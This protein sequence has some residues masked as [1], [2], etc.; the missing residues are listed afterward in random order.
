MSSHEPVARERDL[1]AGSAV[2]LTA[3]LVETVS[4]ADGRRRTRRSVL[5]CA[6][7]G[8]FLVVAITAPALS[9]DGRLADLFAANSTHLSSSDFSGES[10]ATVARL[11]RSLVDRDESGSEWDVLLLRQ[12][13]R[14]AYYRV[15]WR[16]GAQCVSWGRIPERG[17]R[18]LG[19]FICFSPEDVRAFRASGD[20]IT[21]GWVGEQRPSGGRPDLTGVAGLASDGVVRVVARGADGNSIA[22]ATVNNGAFALGA[23]DRADVAMD[24]IRSLV[25]YGSDGRELGHLARP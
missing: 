23:L 11:A 13:A 25:A 21:A 17:P 10:R 24:E 9:L 18:E 1:P 8:T 19:P 15:T 6:V 4:S 5:A 14:R 2:A 16:N 22:S 3:T 7:A 12:D 20:P